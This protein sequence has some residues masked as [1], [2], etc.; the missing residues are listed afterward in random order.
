MAIGGYAIIGD[1]V[2]DD[3]LQSFES[4][5][6]TTIVNVLMAFHVFCAFLIVINP[7]NQDIEQQIGIKHGKHFLSFI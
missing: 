3:V 2:N 6:L 5:I 1:Q 4:G 7:L